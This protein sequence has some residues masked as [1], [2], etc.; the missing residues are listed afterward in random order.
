MAIAD[1]IG[2]AVAALLLAATSVRA[3]DATPFETAC[4]ILER[5]DRWE[6]F[7]L[8]PYPLRGRTRPEKT[9]YFMSLWLTGTPRFHD[10][11]VL[12]SAS[13]NDAATRNALL[14]A[15]KAG[16]NG[17]VELRTY[18]REHFAL[19]RLLGPVIYLMQVDQERGKTLYSYGCFQ[20]R[21]GIRATHNGR[22]V[23]LLICFE[24]TPIY[25]FIDGKEFHTYTADSPQTTFDSV[26][27]QNGLQVAPRL[28]HELLPMPRDAK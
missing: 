15:M 27:R 21:H 2:C 10:W 6:L 28:R 24:C 14:A 18:G 8:D 26:W 25:V 16:V 7:S 19:A 23:E 22:T 4:A 11:G 13:V 12:G 20:P 17:E 1:L 5:A 9:A 3:K